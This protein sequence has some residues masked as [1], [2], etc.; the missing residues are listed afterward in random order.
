MAEPAAEE[1]L[2][3]RPVFLHLKHGEFDWMPSKEQTKEMRD[4][5]K[6]Y[7]GWVHV[8]GGGGNEGARSQFGKRFRFVL[9][10]RQLYAS[11]N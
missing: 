1:I 4:R 8:T 6:S 3:T 5:M 2:T 10:C 11:H 9:P 7:E